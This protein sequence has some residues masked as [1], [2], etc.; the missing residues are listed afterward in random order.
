LAKK[1][2]WPRSKVAKEGK[3][4]PQSAMSGW[5]ESS[6]V[7]AGMTNQQRAAAITRVIKK[8]DRDFRNRYPFLRH[9]DAIGLGMF[10]G[11]A[12]IIVASS[13]LYIRGDI[14]WWVCLPVNAFFLSLIREMDH[15][16]AHGLYFKSRGRMQDLLMLLVWLFLGNQPNP[17]YRRRMHLLHHRATGHQQDFEEQL[18][19]NGMPLGP[20]KLLS[21]LD[22]ALGWLFRLRDLHKIPFYHAWEFFWANFPVAIVYHLTAYVWALGHALALL[23]AGIGLSL[24]GAVPKLLEVLDVLA[25]VYLLPNMIR[26]ASMN[27]QAA[28]M[29]YHGDVSDHLH[30]TQVLDAWWS[31]PLQLFSCCFGATHSIH[32]F[33]VTQPFY[34]RLLVAPRARAAIRHYGVRF[35]D[36]GTL[37]RANRFCAS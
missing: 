20:R 24:P 23:S 10:L 15:D 32:H 18:I 30:E 12:G 21:M 28:T 27:I 29:H 16:L 17:W 26:H 11:S 13:L 6:P 5:V 25:V 4:M 7:V 36:F 3:Q 22:P 31:L 2:S 33:V 34:L 8:S 9:Q 14:P 37:L 35:N 19:G 1:P